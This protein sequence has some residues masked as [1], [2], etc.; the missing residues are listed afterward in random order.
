MFEF[1]LNPNFDSVIT[2]K[3]TLPY[4]EKPYL[5]F[6]F[7]DPMLSGY[8]VTVIED[9]VPEYFDLGE[10][11]FNFS[12]ERLFTIIARFPRPIL[13]EI[14]TH[15]VFSR[16]SAS[17]RARSI[18]STISHVMNDPY[19]PL[20]TTNQK[21]MS[22]KFVSKKTRKLAINQYLKA[23]D[24]AVTHEL[25]LLLG[26]YLNT[27][28]ES[29]SSIASR[30]K[31]LV[32]LYY[33]E[34]YN[35]EIENSKALSVHKQN[36]NRLIENYS[37]HEA[38][39]TSSYWENFLELRNHEAA[40]PEIHALAKLIDVALKTSAPKKQELHLPFV[41][42]SIEENNNFLNMFDILMLSAT[43]CAQISYRDKSRSEKS[44]AT[45][46]LGERLLEMK[47]FSPFEHIAF[48]KEFFDNMNSTPNKK[49]FNS[50]LDNSWVQLRTILD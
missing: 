29:H 1:P 38:I 5:Q 35:N 14:N 41:E 17:S 4:R 49:S 13:S 22:G 30:W 50:N 31:E 10:K 48:S 37:W 23:R 40:Q 26:D 3:V 20:F 6:T 15:R 43:E 2:T 16:N 44:T 47:H 21:G 24:S 25:A 27:D 19:I 7:D 11:D 46:K 33:E 39:I 45:T 42:Y 34:V 8:E 18:K 28:K 32:D 12:T 36:V 9:S